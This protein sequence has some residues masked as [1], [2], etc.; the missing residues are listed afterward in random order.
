MMF[1]ALP[2]CLHLSFPLLHRHALS[3]SCHFSTSLFP[4]S[5]DPD[6]PSRYR[7][8]EDNRK[9]VYRILHELVDEAKKA[10]D[11]AAGAGDGALREA[12]A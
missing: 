2:L 8:R 4:L 3:V 5:F 9:D 7:D 1:C 6:W 11:L 10:D 12:S